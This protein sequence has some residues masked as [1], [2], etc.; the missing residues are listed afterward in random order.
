MTDFSFY[1]KAYDLLLN[2]KE[3]NVIR[4][5]PRKINNLK[6]LRLMID[7]IKTEYPIYS[8]ADNKTIMGFIKDIFKVE[9]DDIQIIQANHKEQTYRPIRINEIKPGVKMKIVEDNYYYFYTFWTYVDTGKVIPLEETDP[10]RYS[11]A[12]MYIL[13]KVKKDKV[14][15][16]NTFEHRIDDVVSHID[17]PNS[18]GIIKDRKFVDDYLSS[19]I[20]IK[21][22]DN[23][24]YTGNKYAVYWADISENTKITFKYWE[25]EYDLINK[26]KLEAM[27]M[28]TNEII[29]K[30][31]HKKVLARIS[32]FIWD[33]SLEDDLLNTYK[34][35]LDQIKKIHPTVGWVYKERNVLVNN[36]SNVFG[37]IL[38][39]YI[40]SDKK[41]KY[42]D[43]KVLKTEYIEKDAKPTY[44]PRVKKNHPTKKKKQI[45]HTKV[46]N[47]NKMV[48]VKH[49]NTGL[50]SRMAR[51]DAEKFVGKFKHYEYATKAEWRKCRNEIAKNK[52]K[53]KPGLNLVPVDE[54]VGIV[55]NR[56]TRR[57]N[58]TTKGSRLV[59]EQF[60]PVKVPETT[61][62]IESIQPTLMSYDENDNELGKVKYE[63]TITKPAHTI[64]KRI[65]TVIKPKERVK[66]TE[67]VILKRMEQSEKDKK[68][69]LEK[70]NL[71][72]LSELKEKF[73]SYERRTDHY[74][75][76]E[77]WSKS[78]MEMVKGILNHT[79]SNTVEFVTTIMTK[80]H[81]L[82]KSEEDIKDFIRYIRL[83]SHG[84]FENTTDWWRKKIHKSK[85]KKP[86]EHV[87]VKF[88][89]KVDHSKIKYNIPE[90]DKDL[91]IK[92]SYEGEEIEKKA[93]FKDNTICT[94]DGGYICELK[95]ILSWKYNE[96]DQY[97]PL[98]TVGEGMFEQV[99]IKFRRKEGHV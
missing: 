17:D 78:F 84:I 50:V 34:I 76:R 79:V 48:C 63:T 61:Y 7:L 57:Y 75:E 47:P 56:K 53:F 52:E 13:D 55:L 38:K 64:T 18:R 67:E 10:I 82:R 33:Q 66:L 3:E 36:H 60:I 88:I 80:I 15:I 25:D 58:N 74:S 39:H 95:E 85:S 37:Y 31:K 94:P 91:F 22:R 72:S 99:P 86:V 30:T 70:K 62:K 27:P 43:V 81:S 83:T 35:P 92:I 96:E 29:Q 77:M 4:F 68:A 26:T 9:S 90:A 6:E 89:T 28:K 21:S 51:R 8:N 93:I 69:Y 46:D 20:M 19:D 59:K 23:K 11:N 98:F 87:P 65:L 5:K 12:F 24:S 54:K 71:K 42:K 45:I 41:N 97:Q 49:T 40:W 14:F 1:N 16:E 44:K 2:L 32:Y 73:A